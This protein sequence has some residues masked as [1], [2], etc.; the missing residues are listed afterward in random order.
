VSAPDGSE[1]PL[2]DGGVFDWLA[3]LASNRRAVHVATG[4]GSQLIALRFRKDKRREQ[5][6]R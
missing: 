3:K 5:P 2:I 6:D 1:V 4:S